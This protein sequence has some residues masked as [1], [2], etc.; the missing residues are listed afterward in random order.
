MREKHKKQTEDA[1]VGSNLKKFREISG[2]SRKE[3]AEIFHITEDALYRIEKGDTGLS[4]TY[5]YT[6]ANEL[7]CNMNYI[8]GTASSPIRIE[9]MNPQDHACRHIARMLRYYADLLEEEREK[10]DRL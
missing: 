9:R 1:V 4:G 10:D 2:I 7:N 3:L 6:L 8:F 5:C